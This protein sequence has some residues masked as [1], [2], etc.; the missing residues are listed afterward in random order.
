MAS[1][2]MTGLK[3]LL[4]LL[5][6]ALVVVA[7]VFFMKQLR[8]VQQ[9]NSESAEFEQAGGEANGGGS[10][11]ADQMKLFSALAAQS[12]HL[13]GDEPV[14][15]RAFFMVSKADCPSCAMLY[16]EFAAFDRLLPFLITPGKSLPV[17]RVPYE[18]HIQFVRDMGVDAVPSFIL[19]DG[20]SYKECS[21]FSIEEWV[22]FIRKELPDLFEP[23]DPTPKSPS[24]SPERIKEVDQDQEELSAR[25]T[26]SSEST[27]ETGEVDDG[28][29]ESENE[30]SQSAEPEEHDS[31]SEESGSRSPSS[32]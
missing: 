10:T 4:S 23:L 21:D 22:A 31:E 20:T 15:E 6:V 27:S 1:S 3:P 28:D 13:G 29:A 8:K 12:R 2:I 11:R 19:K 9:G 18:Q 5:V 7:V 16:S 17:L 32:N 14:P 25:T 24:P 26:S 30:N